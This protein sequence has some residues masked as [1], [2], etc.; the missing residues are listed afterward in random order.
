MIVPPDFVVYPK[1]FHVLLTCLDET[2]D[3]DAWIS[4]VVSP[5]VPEQAWHTPVP[6]QVGQ[7]L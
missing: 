6:K 4:I 5:P 7:G 1:K 3:R 2:I